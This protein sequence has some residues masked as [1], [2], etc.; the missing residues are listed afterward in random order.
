MV[1]YWLLLLLITFGI[2]AIRLLP[3][4]MSDAMVMSGEGFGDISY[5]T[6]REEVLQIMRDDVWRVPISVTLWDQNAEMM[7]DHTLHDD[8]S[9]SKW[10]PPLIRREY[11]ILDRMKYTTVFTFS[12]DPL[13]AIVYRQA[14]LWQRK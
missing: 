1:I 9:S 12:Q 2:V 7:P 4:G 3:K 10:G 5:V 11:E 6:V 13:T 14:C 8:T